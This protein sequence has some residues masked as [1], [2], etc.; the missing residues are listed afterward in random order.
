MLRNLHICVY[1]YLSKG[2]AS[3]SLMKIYFWCWLQQTAITTTMLPLN[4]NK[5]Y[6]TIDFWASF[7]VESKRLRNN[8]KQPN[9]RPTNQP[10][11][12]HVSASAWTDE[13]TVI[14]A[15]LPKPRVRMVAYRCVANFVCLLWQVFLFGLVSWTISRKSV[16]GKL[17]E[18]TKTK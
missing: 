16:H 1:V 8:I 10:L 7:V 5:T 12:I 15:F 2:L 18:Q 11:E 14:P 9:N 17:R 13:C 6:N 3:I 4:N